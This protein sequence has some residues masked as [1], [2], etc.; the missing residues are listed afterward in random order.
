M[1]TA[2]DMTLR[3]LAMGEMVLVFAVLLVQG[4]SAGVAA[5]FGALFV[6]ASAYLVLSGP[7]MD[8]WLGPARPLAIGLSTLPPAVLWLVARRMFDDEFRLRPWHA[9]A[10]I[11]L[12]LVFTVGIGT[13]L[14]PDL[15]RLALSDAARLLNLGLLVHAA[16]RVA[17]GRSA[18]LVEPRRRLRLVA[19]ALVGLEVGATLVVELMVRDP[20]VRDLLNPL[21]AL[22]IF[23]ATTMFGAAW[24]QPIGIALTQRRAAAAPAATPEDPDQGLRD[25]LERLIA[26]G[27]LFENGLTIDRLAKALRAPEYRVRRVINQGLGFR[28][29]NAFLNNHRVGEAKR[30]LGDP[31]LA[32]LPILSIAMDLGYGSLGPFNRAFKAGTG[33]TPSIYRR[34]A[35]G[36]NAES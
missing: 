16:Y 3:L 34:R 12:G 8:L 24:L 15:V 11:A 26:E 25:S 36:E 1:L 9:L 32:R 20:E 17:V 7:D 6:T 14:L 19:V 33:E 21:N 10:L 22:A 23:L 35:L 2:A 4:R 30:R 28:N 5:A 13:A 27:G 18:D 31:A 29:F